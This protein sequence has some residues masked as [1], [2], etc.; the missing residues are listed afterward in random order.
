[1]EQAWLTNKLP[2]QLPGGIDRLYFG[3][4]FCCWRMP[5]FEEILLALDRCRQQQISFTLVTPILYEVW[6]PT[7]RQLMSDL[8]GHLGPDDELLISDLGLI[9]MAQESFPATTLV[10]GRALSG[11]KRGPRILDLELSDAELHYFQ[12]GSCYS[13]ETISFL[14]E[15]GVE[16][17]ELDNLLQGIA[18]LPDGLRG[19]LHVP[20]ALVTTS[21]NCPFRSPQ[22]DRPCQPTCGKMF[23]LETTQ[24][25][26]PLFQ[27]GNSQFLHNDQLPEDLV[28]LGI[29][30]VVQHSGLPA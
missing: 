30:R 26:V 28:A 29:D 14:K 2:E 15:Q 22:H 27:A 23:S 25:Q 4:E 10:C 6:L 5:A 3:A 7:V 17:V 12:Q 11:Q 9:G 13:A 16:R 20:Y 18:P 1:M 19:S 24:T 8:Q 21:R